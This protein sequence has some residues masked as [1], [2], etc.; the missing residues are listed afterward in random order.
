MKRQLGI[1]IPHSLLRP[2]RHPRRFR[3]RPPLILP[4]LAHQASGPLV[5]GPLA[6][7]V[8]H[9]TTGAAAPP[10]R[11][12]T[13]ATLPYLD[14][15]PQLPLPPSPPTLIPSDQPRDRAPTRTHARPSSSPDTV[16]NLGTT[17]TNRPKTRLRSR[18]SAPL[19][20]N[21]DPYFPGGSPCPI[22]GAFSGRDSAVTGRVVPQAARG[23]RGTPGPGGGGRTRARAR[24]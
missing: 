11:G 21:F 12:R 3:S 1:Q 15:C 23:G 20:P 2:S 5:F 16:I 8:C 18:V 22:R 24:A 9:R 17:Y 7:V 4:R 13:P 10:A 19:V 14:P 6:F